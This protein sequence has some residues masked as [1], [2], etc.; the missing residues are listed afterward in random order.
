M[1]V[2][3][4]HYCIICTIQVHRSWRLR[5]VLEAV[6]VLSSSSLSQVLLGVCCVTVAWF[7]C[8][9]DGLTPN[10][11][12]NEQTWSLTYISA[13]QF[14][15]SRQKQQPWNKWSVLF[16]ITCW[17]FFGSWSAGRWTSLKCLHTCTQCFNVLNSQVCFEKIKATVYTARINI[18]QVTNKKIQYCSI[19]WL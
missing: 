12:V 3:W 13:Y 6:V 15:L 5:T 1:S 2:V 4:L 10:S 18:Q 8:F 16:T 9:N 17:F 11:L 7:V 19:C 14:M